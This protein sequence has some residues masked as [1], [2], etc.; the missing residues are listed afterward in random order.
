MTSIRKKLEK[1]GIKVNDGHSAQQVVRSNISLTLPTP[2]CLC[3]VFGHFVH[4]MWAGRVRLVSRERREW[5]RPEI[6][7]EFLRR[8]RLRP[9]GRR[10]V[11]R[12]RAACVLHRVL[13]L[14]P[15]VVRVGRS[16]AG[17]CICGGSLR[18][19]RS[20]IALLSVR[21]REVSIF[22]HM[23]HRKQINIY[24]LMCKLILLDKAK[25]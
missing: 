19:F 2:S 10:Q 13:G 24:F 17:G 11:S 22:D 6:A 25:Q 1:I 21:K 3:S 5:T 18:Q 7:A 14:G 23:L 8:R 20:H 12:A 4:Q 16:G 9:G 15:I